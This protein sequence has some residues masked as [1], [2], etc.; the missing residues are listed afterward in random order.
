MRS[1][2]AEDDWDFTPVLD[3]INSLSS[4]SEKLAQTDV[5]VVES[6]ESSIAGSLIDDLETSSGLGNFDKLWKFLAQPSNIQPSKAHGLPEISSTVGLSDALDLAAASNKGVKWRDEIEGADL[7]DNDEIDSG[8]NF[9]S[10]S[11]TQRRKERRRKRQQSE[12]QAKYH[13]KALPSG[14]ENESEVD[15]K[16]KRSQD[17]AAIIQQILH[18]ALPKQGKGS[19]GR[20]EK[21]QAQSDNESSR[22]RPLRGS[23]TAVFSSEQ[24]GYATAAEKKAK[25][26]DK[27][28]A[29]F[30]EERQYL[31][32]I[33]APLHNTSGDLGT[34]T[35]LHVF[36]DASNIMIGFQYALKLSRGITGRIRRQD[37]SFHNLSLVLERGRP[38]AKK[39]LVGSDNFPAIEEAKAIGY[40]TNILERVHKARELT[41]RQAR[42]NSHSSNNNS[43]AAQSSGSEKTAG[44]TTAYAPEKWVEQAVDEILHLKILESVVDATTPAT[45]VLATG[46]AAEAEYSGGFLRMV[47]RA[48]AKGWKVELVSFKHN[49]SGAY[50]R[51][52]FRTKWGPRFRMVELDGFVE[53]LLGG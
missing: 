1:G 2:L 4:G 15:R 48:L 19:I 25:L 22:R 27:L 31:D 52:D 6:H 41:P 26:M 21:P 38:T 50:R 23:L 17:R 29:K 13:S 43:T 37:L 33:G 16:V 10:L 11:K 51:Q 45:I 14:S 30:K 35:G 39:V 9:A 8:T 7:A 12:V 53:E 40:E 47:E 18:G 3:L 49:T 32:N 20:L 24:T 42:Y 44:R 36:V 46:D 34:E 28:R 5:S